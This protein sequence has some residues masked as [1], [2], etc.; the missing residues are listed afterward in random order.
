M[1]PRIGVRLCQSSGARRKEDIRIQ[2]ICGPVKKNVKLGPRDFHP[3]RRKVS[4]LK[5][6][7]RALHRDAVRCM[8][9]A[10]RQVRRNSR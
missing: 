6:A 8:F 2:H 5:N 10:I 9:S 1:E 3:D 4:G 7:N